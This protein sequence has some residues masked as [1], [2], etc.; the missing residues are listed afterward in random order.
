MSNGPLPLNLLCKRIQ[1][2]TGRKKRNLSC[3]QIWFPILDILQGMFDMYSE[4]VRLNANQRQQCRNV[5]FE[6]LTSV[7]FAIVKCPCDG[8]SIYHILQWG[9]MLQPRVTGWHL[10]MTVSATLVYCPRSPPLVWPSTPVSAQLSCR[11]HLYLQPEGRG[12]VKNPRRLS[13]A[14][15]RRPR[16]RPQNWGEHC[17]RHPTSS[18]TVGLPTG[19]QPLLLVP[20]LQ[21]RGKSLSGVEFQRFASVE[22]WRSSQ[23]GIVGHL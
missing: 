6:W 3:V 11:R 22:E 12:M 20:S 2:L 9:R 7:M 21:P 10:K 8:Y 13:H 15:G 14:M 5:H 16:Q 4:M 18:S 17:L 23:C 1:R 19:G